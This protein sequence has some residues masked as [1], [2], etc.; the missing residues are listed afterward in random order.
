MNTSA[1]ARAIWRLLMAYG[2]VPLTGTSCLL[3]VTPEEVEKIVLEMRRSMGRASID[4]YDG[5]IILK[6]R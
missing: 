1:L 5:F 2:M 6:G 4:L 3:G